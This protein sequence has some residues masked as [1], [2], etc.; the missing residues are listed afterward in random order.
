[1]LSFRRCD[2]WPAIRV[3]PYDI[4]LSSDITAHID[5]IWDE[6]KEKAGGSLFNGRFFSLLPGHG[7]EGFFADYKFWLAQRVDPSL[8]TVL[9]LRPLAV[10]GLVRCADGILFGRRGAKVQQAP[11]CWEL[12]PSGGIA[13]TAFIEGED[14]IDPL[15]QFFDELQEETG[16]LPDDLSS[17]Y[18]LGILEDHNEHVVDIVIA[19]ATNATRHEIMQLSDITKEKEHQ[20]IT[21]VGDR[22]IGSFMDKNSSLLLETS[23]RILQEAGLPESPKARGQI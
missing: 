12:I 16:L 14:R 6:G 15:R 17:V 8:Y 23:H 22:E 5:K 11:G 21:V 9:K 19:A 10:T 1:M 18:P 3:V 4:S 20:E 7:D 2:E 13:D